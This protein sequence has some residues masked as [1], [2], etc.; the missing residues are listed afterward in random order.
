[1]HIVI[2][3]IHNDNNNNNNNKCLLNFG[4]GLNVL[5]YFSSSSSSSSSS[6][7]KNNKL[8]YTTFKLNF[9][10]IYPKSMARN[11]ALIPNN[12]NKMKEEKKN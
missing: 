4:H 10:Q 1:M 7:K 5:Q 9:A 3:L 2:V 6:N 11:Q 8:N 12:N